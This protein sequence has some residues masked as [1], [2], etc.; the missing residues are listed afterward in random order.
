MHGGETI[1]NPLRF[2]A[3]DRFTHNGSDSEFS[4][5]SFDA[6]PYSPITTDYSTSSM[7]QSVS[8]DNDHNIN[9]ELTGVDCEF[10]LLNET[11]PVS[12][13]P[14]NG[15]EPNNMSSSL[16]TNWSG[17]KL[18]IDNL[19]KNFRHTFKR[20]DG[21]T[22]SMHICHVFG[23]IDRIDFL[24]YCDDDPVDVEKLLL[25]DD[26]KLKVKEDAVILVSR[27]EKDANIYDVHCT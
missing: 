22:Q 26:D 5:Y 8:P 13:D 2:E 12:L 23:V 15:L 21:K 3:N 14:V 4:E 25:T 18:V 6:P 17:F 11:E 1:F 19:N 24:S 16:S 7:S 27:Y 9:Y 20:S 10:D